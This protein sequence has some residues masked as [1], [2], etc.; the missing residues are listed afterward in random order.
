VTYSS[1]VLADTPIGYWRLGD[2]SG[3]TMT[4][5]SGNSRNGTYANSPTLGTTGLLTSDS[6]TAVTFASASSQSAS[7]PDDNSLDN[8]TAITVEAWIKPSTVSGT[9]LIV[10]RDTSTVRSFQFRLNAGKLEFLKT[11]GTIVTAASASTL[12]TGTV[13]HVAAVYN[14]TDIRLYINGVL[15]GTPASATGGMGIIT[16]PLEIGVRAGTNFFNGVIDEV[17]VYGTGVSATRIAAHYAAGTAVSVTGTLAV[18]LDDT[19]LAASGEETFSGTLAST[20]DDTTLAATG[21]ETFTGTLAATLDDTTLVASG[22]E[23]F[24]GTLAATLDDTTLA[25]AGLVANPVTGTLATTLD[26]TQF[27]ATGDETFTGTLSTTL[28]DTTLSAAGAVAIPVTGTLATTLAD[29]TLVATGTSLT[30]LPTPTS[31]TY[32]IRR[33]TRTS[34]ILA[35]TRTRTILAEHRTLSIPAEPRTRTIPAEPRTLEVTT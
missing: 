10:N 23:T 19:T 8:L 12:S 28:D 30:I 33:E 1:E 29:T 17:A 20:L 27:V 5:S 32:V 22:A 14:G 34:S 11:T 3:T 4:D 6:D 26:D 35:E 2:A 18:T 16:R 21:A 25:S 31:R 13:Y 7:V 9:P 15:D 24:S